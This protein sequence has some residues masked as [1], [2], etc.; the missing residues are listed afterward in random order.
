ME[1]IPFNLCW[2]TKD[3]FRGVSVALWF[4]NQSSLTR[5][6]LRLPLHNSDKQVQS[7]MFSLLSS[8]CTKNI[9]WGERFQR[10]KGRLCREQKVTVI[11]LGKLKHVI[12]DTDKVHGMKFK[13][14]LLN[15][16]KG[17]V[18]LQQIITVWCVSFGNHSCYCLRLCDPCVWETSV[19]RC[20]LKCILNITKF[21]ECRNTYMSPS[22]QFECLE[23]F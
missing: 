23:F 3:F 11:I 10:I 18:I 2:H 13:K 21:E 19:R 16:C 8:P 5:E 20:Y 14:V 9:P 6:T 22:Y 4:R 7:S 1:S 12:L 17:L 15:L